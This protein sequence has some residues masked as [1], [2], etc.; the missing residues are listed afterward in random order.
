VGGGGGVLRIFAD[1]R[2]RLRV[3]GHTVWWGP[4]RFVTAF[5]E[6]DEVDI[7]PWMSSSK[8]VI[9]VLV[10]FFGAS[11]YQT[12]P[13]G[14]PCFWCSGRAGGEDVSTPGNWRAERL[15]AWRSDAPAFSFA[16]GPVEICDTR[17]LECGEAVGI[18]VLGV[19]DCPWSEPK[20]FSG[21]PLRM[22]E[23]IKPVLVE[24]TGTLRDDEVRVGFVCRLPGAEKIVGES[25]EERFWVGFR[26]WIRS[27]RRQVVRVSCFWSELFCN[28]QQ[29]CIDTD[30][31]FGNHAYCEM[32]FAEG[33]NC[34]TGRVEV[35]SEIWSYCLGF[36]REAGL[37]VRALPGQDCESVFQVGPLQPKRE[38]VL[39]EADE[40]ELPEGWRFESGDL[41]AVTPARVVA[42]DCL[43]ANAI[44]KLPYEQLEGVS[45]WTASQALWSFSFEAE[46]MG[47]VEA[48]VE[49]PEGAVLD[50]SC[51]DWQTDVGT[52]ALYQSN[53][54]TDATDRFLL[55]GGRQRVELFHPRGGKFLQ[56]TLRT[57]DGA[58]AK[59]S[60]CDVSVRRRGR[61]VGDET[62]FSC[63]DE[64]MNWVWPTALRTLVCSTDEVY[65]DCPWRERAC[66]IGDLHVNLHLD[67]ILTGDL[68]TAR[69]CISLFAQAALPDGQLPGCSPSWLRK[70]H[71]DYTLIWILTLRDYW[72]LTG[73]LEFVAEMWSTV[74]N[75]WKSPIWKQG[76]GG[77]WDLHKGRL[78]VDWGILQSERSGAGN[79]VLNLFRYA[80]LCATTELSSALGLRSLETKF[81]EQTKALEADIYEQLWDYERGRLS[82][83]VGQVT[84]ALHANVLALAFGVGGIERRMQIL[85]SI[86]PELVANFKKGVKQPQ[87]SGHLE[88]YFFHYLLPALAEHGR[89]DLAEKIISEHYGYLKNLGENTLPE[90][91]CRLEDFVGSRCHSWSG[92]AAVYAAR[93]IL[94]VRIFKNGLPNQLVFQPIVYGVNFAEGRIFHP[95]GWIEVK[96]HKDKGQFNYTISKPKQVIVNQNFTKITNTLLTVLK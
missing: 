38:V 93:Y 62:Y 11:S 31:P 77:L 15:K 92:A 54:F 96:W 44:R 27:P 59:L 30:T 9:E 87:R 35:L 69:R 23:A 80:A 41:S 63:D 36:P 42:W 56:L 20:P 17:L 3:N 2:Y 24:V 66:Y 28:G 4:P 7:S 8:N 45:E 5:P 65:A 58:P 18:K 76:P 75:I 70:A 89:P 14:R 47:Y 86:E 19:E 68:R 67:A 6:Y 39:P 46:F 12:M 48:E 40:I 72:A 43:E 10:N 81:W 52:V 1:T 57:S 29:V 51:D 16:Q 71:E 55:R 32:E 82:S 61:I 64:I 49:A 73:D 60:V 95:E 90:C 34:V 84:P 26:T 53:P 83:A 13:D 79:A 85:E 37:L 94:G 25:A 91:F 88:F 78:F 21:I 22:D 33:W 50:V 74:M